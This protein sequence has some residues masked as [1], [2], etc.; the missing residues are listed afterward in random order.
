MD[1]CPGDPNKVE[2]GNNGCGNPED[3]GG[4]DDGGGSGGGTNCFIGT[5][6]NGLLFTNEIFDIN[7]IAIWDLTGRS[8]E[9]GQFLSSIEESSYLF[10]QKVSK[11]WLVSHKS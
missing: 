10:H 9:T 2:P 11:T 3:G 5:L 4:S 7:H 6:R 1:A 8:I